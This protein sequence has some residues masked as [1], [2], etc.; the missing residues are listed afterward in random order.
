MIGHV[1]DASLFN[2]KHESCVFLRGLVRADASKPFEG[3]LRAQPGADQDFWVRL[4]FEGLPLVCYGCG[5]LDH[6]IRS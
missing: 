1:S 6:S 2:T 5:L 3:R 4:R